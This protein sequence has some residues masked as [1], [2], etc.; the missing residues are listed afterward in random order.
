MKSIS[1]KAFAKVNLCLDVKGLLDNGYHDVAMILQ[2]I[3]LHDDVRLSWEDTES[4]RPGRGDEADVRRIRE[5]LGEVNDD[6]ATSDR[7]GSIEIELGSNR[8]D[9]PLDDSNLAWKAA[10]EMAA[11]CGDVRGRLGIWIEKRIPMAAGLAG[12]SSDCAAVI[13]GLN[14]IWDLDMDLSQLCEVG[15]R[16][17][18]DVP[19]CI[20]GQAAAD[21]VLKENFSE[22]ESVAHC[23]VA[24]G[25]GTKLRPIQ[26]LVS[27][28]ILAKPDIS[29][30]TKEV[31]DGIDGMTIDTR[32]DIEE[33]ESGLKKN[34]L[35]TIEKNMVNVLENFTLKRYP[36]VVYTKDKVQDLCKGPVL[37]SGSGPTIYCLC[38]TEEEA[39]TVSRELE[40]VGIESYC[41]ETT[42]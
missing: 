28:I 3:A 17:G 14:R 11:L 7:A 32:P 31:Y 26:G 1:I 34:D 19:F 35:G 4:I 22:D 2:Q 10:E 29:V 33:M 21:P 42:F 20:M 41:T 6:E 15:A 12:G 8:G 23:A 25:R 9:I 36:V 38:N 24:V 16:L 18:S 30:S 5:G 37:M 40:M 39:R 27:H 13:H